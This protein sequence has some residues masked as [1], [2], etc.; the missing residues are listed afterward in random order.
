MMKPTERTMAARAVAM[1]ITGFIAGLFPA[2]GNASGIGA[3]YGKRAS[4]GLK[5]FVAATVKVTAVSQPD[6]VTIDERDLARGYV[7]LDRA[8]S[9]LLKSNTPGFTVTANF[10]ASLLSSVAIRMP[11]QANAASHAPAYFATPMPADELV[12]VGY[13]L[14]LNPAARPGTYRWPVTLTFAAQVA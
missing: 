5:V 4:V 8:S 3:G 9:F 7:D 6:R 11:G 12:H 13:R 14:Y 2:H 10:D 1:L